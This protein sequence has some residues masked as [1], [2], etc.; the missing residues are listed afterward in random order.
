MKKIIS[1]VFVIVFAFGCKGTKEIN[2]QYLGKIKKEGVEKNAI[3]YIKADNNLLKRKLNISASINEFNISSKPFNLNFE[4]IN[5]NEISFNLGGIE[6]DLGINKNDKCF[7]GKN[8]QVEIK[9]CY[10][11]NGIGLQFSDLKNTNNNLVVNVIKSSDIS[12]LNNSSNQYTVDE[13]LGRAKFLNFN[14]QENAEVVFRSKEQIK[15][16]LGNLL[17][18]IN[19]S[20]ILGFATAGPV[21]FVSSVGNLAPF[22]FPSNWFQFKE[23]KELN[24]AEVK[25]YAS[26]RGNIVN[27]TEG[28]IYIYLRDQKV[29]SMVEKEIDWLNNVLENIKLKEQS[30]TAPQGS[31]ELF[32]LKVGTLE[33]DLEQLKL[34]F[35]EESS[36]L[37][38]A[39]SINPNIGLS[40]ISPNYPDISGNSNLDPAVCIQS[41]QTNSYELIALDN[42]IK[43]SKYQTD[44]R[45]YSVLDPNGGGIGI[46]TPA[47]IHIGQSYEK[48]LNIKK[49][50]ISSILNKACV[51]STNER[52][53]SLRSYKIADQYLKNASRVKDILTKKMLMG[54]SLDDKVL[55]SVISNADDLLK[56]EAQKHSAL[57]QYLIS[58]GK[59]NRL[60]LLGNY[61]NLEVGL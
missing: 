37:S 40:I 27:S 36:E 47:S 9:L 53:S 49:Q 33:L 38:H 48:E 15:V 32:S 6:Y 28:L 44:E 61:S 60:M 42:M 8:P 35:S 12:S 59:I 19:T 10:E 11:N 7:S 55:D 5:D 25:S 57:I 16:S 56:F 39:V 18:H 58:E 51:D 1:F 29:I 13:L 46:G 26:L 50:E 2:G 4:I 41:V 14:L 34:Y 30:G 45:I 23:A 22:L 31:S 17:P 24:K 20:D 52:N 3:I 54:E 21:S 43:A